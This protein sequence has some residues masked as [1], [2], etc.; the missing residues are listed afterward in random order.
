MARGCAHNFVKIYANST[1]AAR[2]T[3]P[4]ITLCTLDK[5]TVGPG[6]FPLRA[7]DNVVTAFF[8]GEQNVKASLACYRAKGKVCFMGHEI[9][10]LRGLDTFS[11]DG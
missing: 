7:T 4:A 5:Y 11:G 6:E 10:A 1:D 2:E 8:G 9:A 3:P